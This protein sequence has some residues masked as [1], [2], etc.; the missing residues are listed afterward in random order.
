MIDKIIDNMIKLLTIANL[1]I[2]V[3]KQIKDFYDK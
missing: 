2:A 1:L 3:A